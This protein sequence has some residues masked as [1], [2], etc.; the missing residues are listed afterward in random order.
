MAEK[1]Q[2]LDPRS[3]IIGVNLASV[4]LQLGDY[5]SAEQ[6]AQRVLGFD[7]GYAGAHSDLGDL[8][9]DSGRLGEAYLDYRTAFRLDPASAFRQADLGYALFSLGADDEAAAV[10]SSLQEVGPDSVDTHQLLA[11]IGISNGADVGESL[12]V[13][14]QS[15]DRYTRLGA[16]SDYVRVGDEQAALDAY[17]SVLE[18]G[19]Q[20]STLWPDI[21][22]EFP[23]SSCYIAWTLTKTGDENLGEDFAKATLRQLGELPPGE[24]DHIDYMGA[25]VCYLAIGDLDAALATIELQLEHGHY[26]AWLFLHTAPIYDLVRDDPRY[27]AAHEQYEREIEKQRELA[28]F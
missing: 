5:E 22:D 16:A 13:L 21:I 6:E 20:D 2:E 27:I 3:A 19:L 10:T 8:H 25:D 18:Q 14:S 15:T 4:Y 24:I 9:W 26:S 1:A 7:P 28:G 12:Q 23:Y 11:Y 17:L